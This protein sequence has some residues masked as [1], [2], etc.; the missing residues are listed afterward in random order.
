VAD[1]AQYLSG[2]IIFGLGNQTLATGLEIGRILGNW[3]IFGFSNF[4]RSSLLDKRLAIG[5]ILG[6]WEGLLVNLKIQ[7][8]NLI[9]NW[10]LEN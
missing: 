9:G 8:P 2:W 5:Q 1:L 4:H 3:E 10:T 6:N 7:N